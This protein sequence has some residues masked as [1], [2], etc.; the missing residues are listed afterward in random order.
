[1]GAAACSLA[2]RRPLPNTAS[3]KQEMAEEEDVRMR[4]REEQARRGSALTARLLDRIGT[5]SSAT[6]AFGLVR[7]LLLCCKTRTSL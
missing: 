7:R 3:S 5:L 4:Q 2:I 6:A 1:M